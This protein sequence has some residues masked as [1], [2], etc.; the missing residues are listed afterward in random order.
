MPSDQNVISRVAIFNALD[1]DTLSLNP[2]IAPIS[3]KRRIPVAVRDATLN[4]L[5]CPTI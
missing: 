4:L 5:N 1:I 2:R 3:S